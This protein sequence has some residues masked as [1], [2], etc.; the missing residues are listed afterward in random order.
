MATDDVVDQPNI[1]Y[2]HVDNLGFGELSCYSGGPFRGLWTRRIDSFAEEGYRLTNYA[3]E[4]QCTPSRSALLTGRYAIRSGTHSVPLGA[5]SGWGL[6][7][8]ERTIGD[9][10]KDAGYGCA[11][12]GKWHV[13][14]GSGRWPTDKGFEEWYGPPRTYDEC[15]WPDDPWYDPTRDPVA[16]MV[17]IKAGEHDVTERDQLTMDVRRDCDVEYLD[18]AAAFIR[19]KDADGQP[20]FVYFNHSLMHMPVV[21][22]REFEGKTG[23]GEW[24]DSLLELDTDFGTL[25]DLLDELD[26]A[27]NTLVVFA[28]DNGPEEVLLWRGTSGYWEGS[29]FSGSEG[30]LRTPCIVRWPG[31]IAP[32]SVSNDIMHVTDWF[33]TLINAAGAESPTDREIDGVNQLPWLQG[34]EESSRRDGYIY[35]MGPEMYGAKWQNFK[36]VLIAQK[37]STDFVGKLSAPRIINLVTDPKER[38]PL[39][40]PY[41]HSWTVSHFNRL[42][43]GFHASVE[44]ESLVPM[45]A[46]LEFV[47]VHNQS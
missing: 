19:S 23:Q 8:W 31:R 16:K 12:Y 3:P 34:E 7:G 25:L 4:A 10:L 30:N 40:L 24:A 43:G 27:A 2:F 14:E 29:Y 13:G 21:P 22:R 20:F 47:P 33:M 11:A 26:I 9:V 28:G 35:W 46:P 18:R 41:M 15:L 17:D 45:G 36:L 37:Y 44:R 5:P 1:L 32:G 38:E 6:V 42:I 39:D